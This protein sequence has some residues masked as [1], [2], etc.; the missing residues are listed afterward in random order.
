VITPGDEGVYI[1]LQVQPRARHPGVRGVHGDRL[2]VAVSE[3]PEGG[4]ANEAVVEAVAGLLEVK[5]GAVSMVAGG[6]SRQKRVFVA[7]LDADRVRRRIE[8]VSRK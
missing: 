2:K 3:P 5:R 6:S 8:L 7:G 4:K 1:D